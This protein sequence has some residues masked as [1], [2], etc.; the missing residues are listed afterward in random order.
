VAGAQRGAA[1][2]ASRRAAAVYGGV[3]LAGEI[4]DHPGNFTRFLVLERGRVRDEFRANHKT[5]LVC[6][7]ANQPGA[8]AKGIQAFAAN[9]LNLSRLESRPIPESPFEYMFYLDV[10]PAPNADAVRDALMALRACSR[11][12][13]ILGHYPL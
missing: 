1:A 7:L 6:V 10:D 2:I 3:V 12:L 11:S 13:K 9:G 4:Q 5:S 8:L